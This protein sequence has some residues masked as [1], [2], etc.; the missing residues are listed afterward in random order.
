[1]RMNQLKWELNAFYDH[2]LP[3]LEVP[4]ALC[5]RYLLDVAEDD[6]LCWRTGVSS[7]KLQNL[8]TF[9][10]LPDQSTP[11]SHDLKIAVMHVVT[12]SDGNLNHL[13]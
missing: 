12:Q 8:A 5:V 9:A 2:F 3:S 7:A 6:N 13:C 10:K 1:M 11:S 4:V